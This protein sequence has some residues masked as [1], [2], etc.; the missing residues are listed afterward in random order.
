MMNLRKV[1][2][3]ELLTPLRRLDAKGKPSLPVKG[4]VFLL[5]PDKRKL[6]LAEMPS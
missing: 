3:R 5:R 4:E 1:E 2:K 6:L